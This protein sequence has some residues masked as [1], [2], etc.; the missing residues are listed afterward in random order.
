MARRI[1]LRIHRIPPRLTLSMGVVYFSF[2]YF[3]LAP[4]SSSF[5]SLYEWKGIRLLTAAS[6]RRLLPMHRRIRRTPRR[7]IGLVAASTEA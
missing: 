5:I 3:L 4:S 6:H 7:T 1:H 2:I